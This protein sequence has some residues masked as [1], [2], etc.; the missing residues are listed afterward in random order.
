M[1]LDGNK[2]H[3]I[4]C[5]KGWTQDQLAYESS[6]SEKTIW[7]AEN[8]YKGIGVA[9]ARKIADALGVPLTDLKKPEAGEVEASSAQKMAKGDVVPLL[10][11]VTGSG[12]L[13]DR[14]QV[15]QTIAG[16][17]RAEA[18]QSLAKAH[19]E[20]MRAEGFYDGVNY[21]LEQL[22]YPL[23]GKI[24]ERTRSY[25]EDADPENVIDAFDQINRAAGS[26]AFQLQH[27]EN[28]EY[29]LGFIDGLGR[30]KAEAGEL[31]KKLNAQTRKPL[32]EGGS[33]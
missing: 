31:Q 6:C 21:P 32:F 13:Q 17:N 4:R 30:L 33:I 16:G 14:H 11:K 15:R 8:N 1:Q 24:E 28:W 25:R 27:P 23:L 19:S 2:I 12:S 22:E 18:L 29:K 10:P 9:T 5:D 20:N 3:R 7:S 26:S